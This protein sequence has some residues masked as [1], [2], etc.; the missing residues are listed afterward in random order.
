M[1]VSEHVKLQLSSVLWPFSL[2]CFMFS[3][4]FKAFFI[5]YINEYTLTLSTFKI[6]N[7]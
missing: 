2:S 1:K 4:V 6:V 5:R 7:D 3:L